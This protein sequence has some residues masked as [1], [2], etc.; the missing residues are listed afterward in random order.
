MQ[1]LQSVGYRVIPVNPGQ[2]GNTLLGERVYASLADIAE[3]FQM[4]D[5]FRQSSAVAAIVDA[6]IMLA[7]EQGIRAIWMQLNVRDDAA[8][9]RA[10]AS[11]LNVVMNRCPVI[12]YGRLF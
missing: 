5:I 8:A 6:T 9:E 10:T 2:A 3:P 1:Y 11:G 12:E 4:V 7:P